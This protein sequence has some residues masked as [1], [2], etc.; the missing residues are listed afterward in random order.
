MRANRK[1]KM[2]TT[3]GS[4][5]NTSVKRV[6]TFTI[7]GAGAYMPRAIKAEVVF[8]EGVLKIECPI[9]LGPNSMYALDEFI[10]N[11]LD[12]VWRLS[13]QTGIEG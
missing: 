11:F 6:K 7:H 12:D 4:D 3:F 5:T 9:G 10:K 8:P 2:E 1:I 13:P